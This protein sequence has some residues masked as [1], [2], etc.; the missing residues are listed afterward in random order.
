M[1]R[2]VPD[3]RGGVP[4]NLST[5]HAAIADSIRLALKVGSNWHRAGRDAPRRMASSNEGPLSTVKPTFKCPLNGVG[6]WP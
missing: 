2:G 6:E 5:P 3:V 1:Q 4:D